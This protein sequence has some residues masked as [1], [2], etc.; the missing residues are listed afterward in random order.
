MCIVTRYED[1]IEEETYQ[2]KCSQ[3]QYKWFARVESVSTPEKRVI[4]VKNSV[5]GFFPYRTCTRKVA[6]R[7]LAI[8]HF[9]GNFGRMQKSLGRIS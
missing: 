5:Q 3:N 4:A 6:F 9:F 2:N 8:E 7:I 1:V